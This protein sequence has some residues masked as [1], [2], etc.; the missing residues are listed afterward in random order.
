[1]K[2][3]RIFSISIFLVLAGL[4]ALTF[5][6]YLAEDH[7]PPVITCDSEILAINVTDDETVLC[8]GITAWDNQDGDLTS[9]VF[10]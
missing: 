9:Q 4:T 5:T 6:R 8:Q 2:A 10:V 7:T 3:I 1:M